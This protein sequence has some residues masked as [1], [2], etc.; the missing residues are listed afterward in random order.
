MAP[1][2]LILFCPG[3]RVTYLGG[4]RSSGGKRWRDGR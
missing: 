4:Q 1:M 3:E 2:A